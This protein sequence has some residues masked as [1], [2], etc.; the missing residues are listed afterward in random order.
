MKRN[1]KL[2]EEFSKLPE[3]IRLKELDEYISNNTSISNK[4]S[5]AKLLQK[6][7][8]NSKEFNQPNQYKEYK[9]EYDKIL[10]ELYDMPFVEEYL[11]L[12]D[13]IN[14]EIKNCF[15]LVEGII[16]KKLN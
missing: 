10:E 15:G 5:E 1:S 6:K 7:M 16:N 13:T 12:V 9:M 8:V 14:E 2:I 11:E 4:F 3:V